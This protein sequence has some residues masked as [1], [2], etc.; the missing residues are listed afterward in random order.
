VSGFDPGW[1]DLREPA[2][3]RSIAAGPFARFRALVGRVDPIS[4]ADLGAGSG[5]TLRLL[6]PHLGSEQRWTLI[7]H[8]PAL[9]AHARARLSAWADA[10]T[11]DGSRLR[12]MKAGK[13]VEVATEV[14]DLAHDS[15]PDSAATSDVVVASAFF[16]LVGERWLK[17]FVERLSAAG[18]P[19]YAR[20]TYDGRKSFEPP[21]PLDAPT[22]TAFNAHQRTDKGLGSS[23]GPSAG[24]RL[25]DLAEAAG[26]EVVSGPS[27]WFLGPGD[28]SLVL[29]LVEG[30]AGAV[31]TTGASPAGLADWLAFRRS[32]VVTGSAEV[33]HVDLLLTSSA[34]APRPS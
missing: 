26:Y 11:S 8:D 7:D 12:L 28:A 18:R 32:T 15:L 1:L 20:L 13:V 9:L 6:A 22:L 29:R 14:R 34:P 27:P 33:G 2:D 10:A 17:D 3:H 4:V 25:A 31:S 5:S 30:M 16:D 21:H 24:V 19:L 23:L